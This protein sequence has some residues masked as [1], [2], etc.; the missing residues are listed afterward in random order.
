MGV[1]L[2]PHPHYPKQVERL[3]SIVLDVFPSKADEDPRLPKELRI[4]DANK[5]KLSTILNSV[6]NGLI[7]H[8]S[9]TDIEQPNATE[10]IA[11]SII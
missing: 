11:S 3:L 4:Y 6:D 9:S 7:V 2:D 8:R 5:D 1:N 10:V